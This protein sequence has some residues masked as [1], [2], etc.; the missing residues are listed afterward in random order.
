[1]LLSVIIVSYNVRYYLHQCLLSVFKAGAGIAME[2][3]VVDNDS[4][5]GS[6]EYLRQHFPADQYP[7]LH[8][9]ASKRN[10]G[11]GRA[12]NMAV[13]QSTG[14]YVLFLNP[15][16]ILTEDTLSDC[17][18]FAKAHP[19]MGGLGVMMLRDDGAF[20]LESRRGLPTPWTSFCKMSGLAAFFPKSRL[21]GRYYM[22]YLDKEQPAEIE[23]ISG[24]FMLCSREA[25]NKVGLF[26]KRFFMYGED[27]DLSYRLLLGGYKNYYVPTPIIHYKGESTRKNTYRYV[28]VFYEAMLIFFRKH[29]RGWG[30]LLSL[31][32][33]LAIL[34]RALIALIAQNLRKAKRFCFPQKSRAR[35]Q[36]IYIG[37]HEAAVQRT[38]RSQGDDMPCV[39][40][41]EASHPRGHQDASLQRH[42]ETCLVYDTSDFSFRT[43]LN[44]FRRDPARWRIGTFYPETDMLIS[45]G[46]TFVK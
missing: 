33:T 8:F 28:H 1:M 22:R 45:G 10:L 38:F 21:F 20:A 11:F 3:L 42:G 46:E 23:I 27:I 39:Q 6:V 5:D 30:R 15:D 29:Y 4:Q 16:T 34:C 44:A 35:V 19:D 9:I 17:L 43:I 2:V 12:N 40:A 18:Q 32:V 37:S 41:T 14:K 26:D 31:P 24:A 7:A 36:Y 25:L 13:E